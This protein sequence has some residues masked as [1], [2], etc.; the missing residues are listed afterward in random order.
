VAGKDVIWLSRI[1]LASI[2][3]A[4]CGFAIVFYQQESATKYVMMEVPTVLVVVEI[5][6]TPTKTSTPTRTPTSFPTFTPTSW[7]KYDPASPQAG[8]LVVP[9]WT[10]T[11]V[12]PVTTEPEELLPCITVTPDKYFDTFCEVSG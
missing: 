5:P 12:I 3:L 8:V 9:R 10:E 6:P 11:P 2:A 4:A 1:A 7:P